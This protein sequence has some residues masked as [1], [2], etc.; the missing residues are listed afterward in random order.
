MKKLKYLQR[1]FML[2]F[3]GFALCAVQA[4]GDNEENEPIQ[5]PNEEEVVKPDDGKEEDEPSNNPTIG[6]INGH[7][8]VDLGLSVKWATC[9]VGASKPEDY[10]DYFVWSETSPRPRSDK[11][12]S[13]TYEKDFSDIS[14]NVL[15]DAARANWGDSWRLPTKEELKELEAHCTWTWTNR[16]DHNGYEVTGPNGNKI[17]LP[18]TGRQHGSS[19]LR[20]EECGYYWSS[21]PDESD[22][23]EVWVLN[24]YGPSYGLGTFDRGY[25]QS[26]RPVTD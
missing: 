19:L 25:I 17:F 8:Y 20:A 12:N 13:V 21:T 4:C 24:F 7:E 16:G 6:T 1:F 14:G 11:Q 9:N 3:T 18:A 23:K 5:E 26:V 10:G 22:T 15:Y 2:L